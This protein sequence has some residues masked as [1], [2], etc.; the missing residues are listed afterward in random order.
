[1]EPERDIEK[2]LKAYAQQRRAAA[3]APPPLH[4]ANRKA[5]QAEAAQ[6]AKS[7][8]SPARPWWQI[9]FGSWPRLAVAGAAVALVV[10]VTL[11]LLSPTETRHE[12]SQSFAEKRE[13]LQTFAAA[14]RSLEESKAMP[15]TPPPA[16]QPTALAAESRAAAKTSSIALA[17]TASPPPAP[18]A[19]PIAA[20]PA[21]SA[22]ALAL[23]SPASRDRFALSSSGQLAQTTNSLAPPLGVSGGALAGSAQRIYRLTADS[24]PAALITQRFR[25]TNLPVKTAKPFGVSNLL[26]TFKVEQDLDKLRVIDSDGS[27]YFGFVEQTPEAGNRSDGLVEKE[28]LKKDAMQPKPARPVQAFHFRVS[29]TNRTL[30]EEVIFTGNFL[31]PLAPQP[32]FKAKEP[33]DGVAAVP[34]ST[35]TTNAIVFGAPATVAPGAMSQPVLFELQ[36]ARMEG[37]LLLGGSNKI[38]IKAAPVKP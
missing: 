34:Q 10:I 1:V 21:P 37:R 20:A 16:Q 18:V 25:R 6:L 12:G 17:D 19:A 24:E 7:S 32:L 29:G 5:L 36:K 22:Q 27:V 11:H 23:N 33:T 2:E 38:E 9:F 13:Q 31:A 14:R 28:L 3:G 15:A 4:P 26:A 8:G 30:K 35:L